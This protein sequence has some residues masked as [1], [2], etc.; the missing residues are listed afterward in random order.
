MPA[1]I[2]KRPDTRYLAESPITT[3]ISQR[4]TNLTAAGS[5][6][7]EPSSART[8][9]AGTGAGRSIEVRCEIDDASAGVLVDH[10]KGD[11]Y[12]IRVTAGGHVVFSDANGDLA[13][14]DAPLI[15]GVAQGYVIA[16]STEPN[17]LGTIG[18]PDELRSE[19]RV[20]GGPAGD[21]ELAWDSVNHASAPADV[22]GTFTVGGVYTGGMMTLA[23]SDTIEIVRISCRFHTGTETR[24]HFVAQTSAPVVEGI[25]AC[26]RPR[27]PPQIIEP[28]QIVGPAYQM[29]AASMKSGANR[30]RLLSPV[31]Q[32]Q[33]PQPEAFA[34][35]IRDNLTHKLAWNMPGGEGWQVP[36]WVAR[37]QIPPHAGHLRVMIQLV[38]FTIDPMEAMDDVEIRFHTSNRRPYLATLESHITLT[39]NVDDGSSTALG[40]LVVFDDFC[41]VQRGPDGYTWLWW[42]M[43]TDGGSGSGNASYAIR[44]WSATPI[45]LAPGYNGEPLAAWDP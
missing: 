9:L 14:V 29:A 13:T 30:H 31:W 32:R 40:A 34:D 21:E 5:G 17:P 22:A 36:L 7:Y 35:D 16:W 24:E 2:R 6:G 12:R 8:A 45:V 11:G 18:D 25:Q 19:F 39:R 37:R 1:N 33:I 44:G 4:H 23:Y 15:A 20:Y 28:G 10:D 3:D 42:S 27:I 26:E 38:T 43:R 41:P